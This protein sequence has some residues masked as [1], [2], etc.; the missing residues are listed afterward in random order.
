MRSH[1]FWNNLVLPSLNHNRSPVVGV[2]SI[3]TKFETDALVLTM[4]KAFGGDYKILVVDP[5]P[6]TM[7]TD[8]HKLIF[9]LP[10]TQIAKSGPADEAAYWSVSENKL[11]GHVDAPEAWMREIY[12]ALKKAFGK[13][14]F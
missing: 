7:V 2:N 12:V 4:Q 3:G 1:D 5:P 13:D 14:S 8:R 10:Q 11:K 6:Q 9:A